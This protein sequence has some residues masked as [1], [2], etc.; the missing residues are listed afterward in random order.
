MNKKIIPFDKVSLP[1]VFAIFASLF[2]ILSGLSWP[3]I[4]S[5][6]HLLFDYEYGI[7]KRWLVGE[8]LSFGFNTAVSYDIL[9]IISVTF[10]L[11]WLFL[12]FFRLL[13]LGKDDSYIWLISAVVLISPGFI[14]LV[15]EIGYFDHVG[16]I[17]L[18]LCF[19]LPKN[20]TGL[21]GRLFLCA[22]MILV[23]E[24]FFLMFFPT[25]VLEYLIGP[26]Q[27]CIRKRLPTTLFL[28]ATIAGLT[29]VVGQQTLAV[30]QTDSY[31]EHVD[32][33]ALNFSIRPDAVEVLFRD[34]NEN[35]K[36]VSELWEVRRRWVSTAMAILF[37]L[38]LP[39][40]LALISLSMIDSYALAS[41][42]EVSTQLWRFCLR[43]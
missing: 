22:I 23:H 35:I 16:L 7:I 31:V 40:S 2:G 8:I 24:A 5:V 11:I 10:F 28:I 1:V 17:I 4:W 9:V 25:V 6:T 19:L 26:T 42:C 15:H 3:N 18:L 38:P 33:R 12:L 20:G 27:C 32:E 14:Y 41:N 39:F 29:Y 37:L 30:D 36:I 13:V 21:L 43:I 34:G